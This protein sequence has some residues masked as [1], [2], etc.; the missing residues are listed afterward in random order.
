MRKWT[1]R[2]SVE[3]PMDS[4]LL[5]RGQMALHRGEGRESGCHCSNAG[6]CREKHP[7]LQCTL[8]RDAEPEAMKP[9]ESPRASEEVKGAATRQPQKV[10]LSEE[11]WLSLFKSTQAW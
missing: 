3:Q 5:A 2:I 1:S 11:A 7:Y 6:Q 9:T 4:F 10:A 8:P